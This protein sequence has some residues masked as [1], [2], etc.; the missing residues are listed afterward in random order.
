MEKVGI[1]ME[2]KI[3]LKHHLIGWENIDYDGDG[4]FD[5]R[6]KGEGKKIQMRKIRN[7]SK[8]ELRKEIKDL[9]R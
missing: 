7:E 2:S 9:E 6:F 1:K 4:R 3:R 5:L 8:R